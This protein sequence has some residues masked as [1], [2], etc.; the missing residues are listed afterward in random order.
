[1]KNDHL[2]FMWLA[3]EEAMKI[4]KPYAAVIVM[5]WKVIS[6][7][8]TWDFN[9][10]TA[11]AEIKAI[12]KAC[13]LLNVKYLNW[14]TIYTTAEPCAMCF[15]AI[16]R[17]KIDLIVYWISIQDSFDF[18]SREILIDSDLLNDKSWNRVQI[19]GWVMR[20]EIFN[21]FKKIK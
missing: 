3:F 18:C 16:L 5:D 10:P 14:C 8:Y 20:D 19:I 12:R 2:Y 9:D 7:A 17:A 21:Y 4:K 15:A 13:Q 11:H 6:S 1:M